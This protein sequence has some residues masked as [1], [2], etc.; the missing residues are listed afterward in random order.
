MDETYASIMEMGL[1][2]DNTQEQLGVAA[3]KLACT[4]QLM[5]LLIRY[6]GRR[7]WHGVGASALISNMTD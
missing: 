2:L 6:G 1:V 7:R 3:N 5:L 4:V